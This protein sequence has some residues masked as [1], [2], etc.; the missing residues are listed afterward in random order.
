VKLLVDALPLRHGG[1]ATYLRSQLAALA[2][3]APDL[4]VES[5]VTPWNAI[6]GLPGVTRT[7]KVRSVPQRFG[8][9]I[10]CL[11]FHR[12]DVLY[13]PAN[14]A[15]LAARAPVVLAVHNPN[16]FRSGRA[17]SETKSSRPQWKLWA[18]HAA[19]RNAAAVIAISTSLAD[20]MLATYPFVAR[21]LHIIRSGSPTWDTVATPVDGLPSEY[22]LTVTSAAPHKRNEDV[23]RGWATARDKSAAIPP[24]VVVGGLSADQQ[25]HCR[26]AAGRH[27]DA[28]VFCGRIGDRGPLRWIYEHANAMVSMSALEAFPLTPAEA[29]SVGCPLVLSDIPPH[30]EVTNGNATFVAPGAVDD[31]ATTLTDRRSE[32][33]PGSQH[34]E[35]PMSWAD[36]AR[37][38]RSLFDEV[39]RKR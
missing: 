22:L 31:L 27:G 24:L 34:W 36:H 28:I 17:L 12:P 26:V 25:R 4:D 39:A 10:A 37:V 23:V 5:L 6:G 1:G 18:N 30:H 35:W 7:V 19:M 32:W 13:C 3:V 20:E 21:K 33:I 14:F 2:E 16:Y 8:Y 11:P 9:E 29:G 15:P 38:L